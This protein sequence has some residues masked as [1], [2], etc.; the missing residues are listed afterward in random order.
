MPLPVAGIVRESDASRVRVG[1]RMPR[2]PGGRQA[3]APTVTLLGL[4][5]GRVLGAAAPHAPSGS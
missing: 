2:D 4:T 3:P 1:R 5:V